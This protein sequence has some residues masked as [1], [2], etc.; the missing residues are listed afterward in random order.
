MRVE[1]E[2]PEDAR[3]AR[4]VAVDD[5]LQVRHP[6]SA[7]VFQL[8]G[9]EQAHVDEDVDRGHDLA[10]RQDARHRALDPGVEQVVAVRGDSWRGRPSRLPGHDLARARRH[11]GA[12]RSAPAFATVSERFRTWFGRSRMVAI[13]AENDGLPNSE[14]ARIEQASSTTTPESTNE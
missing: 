5:L 6:A 14:V 11:T 3:E 2:Y 7:P 4:E 13:I 10:L 12:G 8:L 1:S 9:R